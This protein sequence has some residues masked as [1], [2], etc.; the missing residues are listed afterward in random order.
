MEAAK[1]PLADSPEAFLKPRPWL[2]KFIAWKTLIKNGCPAGVGPGGAICSWIGFN[3]SFNNCPRRNFEE[4]ELIMESVGKVQKL[5]QTNQ[6][7]RKQI[8]EKN[9]Q[10]QNLKN[11]G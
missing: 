11:K 1:P 2:E 4:D 8:K 5:E 7:L 6:Q 3:C 9:Q 10:I